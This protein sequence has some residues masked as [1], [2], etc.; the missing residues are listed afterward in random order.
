ME[1]VFE[2]HGREVVPVVPFFD[3][4]LDVVLHQIH[5]GLH[6]VDDA[7]KNYTF[8]QNHVPIDARSQQVD[9]QTR[10]GGSIWLFLEDQ[11]NLNEIWTSNPYPPAPTNC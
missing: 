10:L 5:N 1:R 3:R 11:S 4:P 9:N 8:S 2:I 7:W 6:E